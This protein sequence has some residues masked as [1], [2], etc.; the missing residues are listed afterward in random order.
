MKDLELLEIAGYVAY[1]ELEV[2]MPIMVNEI[3]FKVVDTAYDNYASG[4]QAATLQNVETGEY[5]IAYQGTDPSDW[6]DIV[7]DVS[8]AG[9]RIHPQLKDAQDYYKTMNERY[10]IQYVC[11]NS[12]GGALAN[13]VAVLN[14][15]IQS[16][17]YNPAI[18]PGNTGEEANNIRNYL[19]KHDPLTIAQLGAGYYERIPGQHI[20]TDNNIPALQFL[21][22]NHV[23]YVED[24]EIRLE[25]R[26]TPIK[27]DLIFGLPFS[28]FT[29][30]FLSYDYQGSGQKITI[31]ESAL[32]A[33]CNGIEKIQNNM[34]YAQ[35]YLDEAKG[36]VDAEGSQFYS[37]LEQLQSTCGEIFNSYE[38]GFFS[39]TFSLNDLKDSLA[40]YKKK[41]NDI[42]EIG[43]VVAMFHFSVALALPYLKDMVIILDRINDLLDI[44][45]R[46][47][48]SIRNNAIPVLF[49]DTHMLFDDGLPMKL[50]HHFTIILSNRDKLMN[51]LETYKT[52][53]SKVWSLMEEGDSMTVQAK[54]IS[55]DSIPIMD[56]TLLEEN[57]Q[58]ENIM[59]EKKIQLEENYKQF[60]V[61]AH[62]ELDG[63]LADLH[64]NISEF[65]NKVIDVSPFIPAVECVTGLISIPLSDDHDISQL[66]QLC[67]FW[68]KEKNKIIPAIQGLVAITYNAQSR[69]DEILEALKPYIKNAIFSN[70]GYNDVMIYSLSAYNIYESASVT[71]EDIN[72]Q[73]S[74]NESQAICKLSDNAGILK[75]DLLVLMRQ[76]EKGTLQ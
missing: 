45:E 50:N 17:T 75:R 66:Y 32:R 69:L 31:D 63:L 54:N 64:R 6:K 43:R 27:V 28:V 14:K 1:D 13:H 34:V 35:T 2:N 11:G 65:Y 61:F 52:Q 70:H 59:Q 18:I 16:V 10:G 33:L 76:I 37:R 39:D 56:D 12:L 24:G 51:R 40:G 3:E 8:L 25:G 4:M 36:I 41:I 44:L 62:N 42:R 5:V 15:D 55:V 53:V 72:Y 74:E 67:K 23:G 30:D 68:S 57:E 58:F 71:F 22:A 20:V 46:G 7:T 9:F 48:Y 19:G 47:Y 21:V 29:N 38:L 60:K 26:G 73:L 49:K